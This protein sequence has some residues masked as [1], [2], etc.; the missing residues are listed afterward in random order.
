MKQTLIRGGTVVTTE[1]AS[2]ADIL[3]SGEKIS[4]VGNLTGVKADVEID[5]TGLLVFPGAIDGHVR[6]NDSSQRGE[7]THDYYSGTLAAAL[8][9]VTSVV[10]VSNQKKG[11]TLLGAIEEKK[12]Q[13]DGLALI[14]WGVHPAITEPSF[15]TIE[16]I[17]LVVAQG[18]PTITCYMND[19][20]KGLAMKDE[21]LER[22]LDAIDFYHGMLIVH[23]EAD[24]RALTRLIEMARRTETQLF[25]TYPAFSEGFALIAE[26]QDDGIGVFGDTQSYS[27]LCPHGLPVIEQRLSVLYS[28]GVA[29]GKM[30]LP[31]FVD[32]IAGMPAAAFGLAYKKGSLEP[33]TDADIVLFDPKREWTMKRQSPP[34]APDR[35][36]YDGLRVTG[37]IKKVFS[38]GELIVDDDRVLA[39]KGRGR[40]LYRRLGTAR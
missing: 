13:A 16:E 12:K 19:P 24:I 4:A 25:V 26:A 14:D 22:V 20:V 35:S 34:L 9:G 40:Y 3:I 27:N 7:G 17:P 36:P 2:E 39:Q 31:K 6:F 37:K 29:K 1:A 30:S 21:D 28:E 15:N 18:A 10:D 5:A 38:R 11:N 33:T 32:V 23:A 8:G